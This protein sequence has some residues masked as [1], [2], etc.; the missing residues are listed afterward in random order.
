MPDRAHARWF[1]VGCRVVSVVFVVCTA[2]AAAWIGIAALVGTA[3]RPEGER[4]R[5]VVGVASTITL[6]VWALTALWL[7]NAVLIDARA[8]RLGRVGLGAATVGGVAALVAAVHP[9]A[10]TAMGS[11]LCAVVGGVVAMVCGFR[12]VLPP[13]PARW[14]ALF[15]VTRVLAIAAALVAIGALVVAFSA[16]S[17]GVLDVAGVLLT[18]A[19]G[20]TVVVLGW[21]A[22]FALWANCSPADRRPGG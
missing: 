3:Q 18:I 19:L 20:L 21:N 14:G 7:A 22:C 5:D 8:P 11:V 17:K 16:Q 9:N 1:E 10:D 13:D 15:R 12:S 6:A 2:L 4:W